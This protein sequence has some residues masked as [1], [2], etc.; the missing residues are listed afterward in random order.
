MC[1]RGVSQAYLISLARQAPQRPLDGDAS[2]AL[3]AQRVHEPC[4][5]HRGTVEVKRLLFKQAHG[6][7][8]NLASLEQQ[9]AHERGLAVIHVTNDGH[10]AARLA[11]H[12]LGRHDRLDNL[13]LERLHLHGG[14]EEA[15][16]R[17]ASIAA[18]A[19]LGEDG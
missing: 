19:R 2:L 17:A 7:A 11:R 8:V 13:T 5:L 16:V 18:L 9:M 6:A 14:R 4:V 1:E 15:K 3:C 10:G 12:A